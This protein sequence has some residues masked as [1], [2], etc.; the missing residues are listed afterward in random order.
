MEQLHY[1][2]SNHRWATQILVKSQVGKVS[3]FKSHV[4]NLNFN[5]ITSG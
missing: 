3:K 4:D 2:I 5:Q 1:V